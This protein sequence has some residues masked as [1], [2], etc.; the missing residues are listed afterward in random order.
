VLL[1]QYDKAAALTRQAL[2]LDPNNVSRY[3]NIA[4]IELALGRFDEARNVVDQAQA[5]KFDNSD[6]HQVLYALALLKGG[7]KAAAEQA[8][9]GKGEPGEEDLMLSLQADTEAQSGHLG[10]AHALSERATKTANLY[11]LP[12]EAANWEAQAGLREAF[13]GDTRLAK[14]SA[15]KA[16]TIA[17]G[18]DT[19][20]MVALALA[21][22]G[23]K[24]GAQK[25][26][27]ELE[28]NY[29]SDT[30][31][32]SYWLPAIGAALTLGAKPAEA[33]ELLRPTEPYDLGA[34]IGY[35]DYAC[36][37]PV[38]IRGLAYLDQGQGEEAK[39]AFQNYLGHPGLVWNCPLTP[40]VHLG[41]A[42]AYAQ[43]GDRATARALYHD[44]L[45]AWNDADPDIP[46]LIAAK[47]EY[48]KLQ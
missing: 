47:S 33:I 4:A 39:T 3:G 26:I 38:Y 23:D 32:N 36:L 1:G 22:V 11:H 45:T 13:F 44:F 37:Y 35:V 27:R 43:Q 9:W 46:I 29:P 6:L 15:Q 14:T 42:R 18:R 40:L 17:E 10:R 16:V 31:V 20:A 25:S 48:A 30:L 8:S 19:T 5:R 34:V 2:K 41:L 7:G 12:E 21:V 24:S 28:N